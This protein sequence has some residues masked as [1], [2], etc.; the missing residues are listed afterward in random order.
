MTGNEF[1][2]DYCNTTSFL[3]LLVKKTIFHFIHIY[4]TYAFSFSEYYIS[5]GNTTTVIVKRI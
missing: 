1:D 4:N 5:A 2:C 3:R